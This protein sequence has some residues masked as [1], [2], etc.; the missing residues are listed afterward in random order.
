MA[1]E[2]VRIS[3]PAITIKHRAI[4]RAAR[5]QILWVAMPV[6]LNSKTELEIKRVKVIV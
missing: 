5:G 1:K 3:T 4:G 2:R 6:M